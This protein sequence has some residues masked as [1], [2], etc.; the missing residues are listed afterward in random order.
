MAI[1]VTNELS[2]YDE[3]SKTP[4]RIHSHW[5]EPKKIVIEF[6]GGGEKRTVIASEL[7]AAIKNATNTDRF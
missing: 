5:N 4:V 3:P 7:L 6:L 2:T 1:K